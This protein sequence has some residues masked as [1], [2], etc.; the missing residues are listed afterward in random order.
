MTM[1]VIY[2]DNAATSHY[3]PM[4]VKWAFFNSLINSANPGRSGH[5]LSLKNAME[6]YKTREV[7]ANH[8]GGIEPENVVFTKNCTEALNIVIQGICNK[9]NGNVIASCFEHNSVLRPLHELER[10]NKITLTIIYPKNKRYIT[11]QDVLEHLKNDTFLVAVGSISNVTGYKNS[12]EKIAELCR[13]KSILYLLD[14]AQG[15]GHIKID[16][17]KLNI[18][19]LTFSGHKG[20]LTP[21]GIG[22]LCINC[23]EKPSPLLFGGTGTESDNL[24]QPLTPPEAYESGTIATNLICSLSA[25][26]K[27]V[28]KNINQNN[29][30]IYNL[31]K[32]LIENLQKIKGV[33]LYSEPNVSGVVGFNVDGFDSVEIT[34]YLDEKYNIATRGGLH[35]APLTHRYL[36]TLK[37]GIVR[38]SL[39]FKNTKKQ[40]DKLLCAIKEKI[41]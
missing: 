22:A 7:V 10:Q 39:C 1:K 18:D 28:E 26:I 30:K 31:T 12:Y 32:Y 34:D 23:K 38:V 40:I 37:S 25:G 36:G 5:K 4:C 17:K 15:V 33:T 6:V 14:N 29:Q 13:K 21:Q 16:M 27:Y 9:K 2:F 19:Y 3:K 8:F 11:E 20:F 41:N 35:C 24:L